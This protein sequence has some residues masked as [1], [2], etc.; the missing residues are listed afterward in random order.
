MHRRWR[1]LPPLQGFLSSKPKLPRLIAS[2]GMVYVWLDEEPHDVVKMDLGRGD[3]TWKELK[4]SHHF[5]KQCV[6]FNGKIYI[7]RSSATETGRHEEWVVMAHYML[8]DECEQV[9]TW[10]HE[11]LRVVF[12]KSLQ[13]AKHYDKGLYAFVEHESVHN[14]R[15]ELLEY[16]SCSDSWRSQEDMSFPGYKWPELAEVKLLNADCFEPPLQTDANTAWADCENEVITWFDSRGTPKSWVCIDY[17]SSPKDMYMEYTQYIGGSLYAVFCKDREIVDDDD[18]E[19]GD[20]DEDD[21]EKNLEGQKDPMLNKSTIMK[22]RINLTSNSVEW[23][24]TVVIGCFE[25]ARD[26]PVE[27]F[28]VMG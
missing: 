7:P 1:K 14:P 10:N 19:E 20:G 3:W 9:E 8:S 6:D 23:E 18:D 12:C 21:K 25:D 13:V 5:N 26:S 17:S 15:L 16:D 22:G 4:L 28:T 24:A 2:S 27:C 11:N